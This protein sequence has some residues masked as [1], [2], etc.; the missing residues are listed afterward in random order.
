MAT[1]LPEIDVEKVKR[2][3]RG[4]VLERLHNE[5]RIEA[6]TRGRSIPSTNAGPS[7]KVPRGIDETSVAQL[8]YEGDGAW[9]LYC[10]D[11]NSKWFL[12]FD[13]ERHQ[14]VDVILE[15]IETTRTGMFWG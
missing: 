2:Y 11:P 5:V 10:A 3:C 1:V 12:Y 4:K 6:S 15:E 13:L 9:T 14:P 8:R 7:R